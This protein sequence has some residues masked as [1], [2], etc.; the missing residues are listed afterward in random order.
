MIKQ[1]LNVRIPEDVYAVLSEVAEQNALSKNSLVVLALRNY[2]SYVQ[3][4]NRL[5]MQ[6]LAPRVSEPRRQ[7]RKLTEPSPNAKCI[8]GSGKR[9]KNCCLNKA[10]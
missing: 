1:K 3:Q 10:S 8:C 4:Y 5:P 6:N 9:Y 7:R 2:L